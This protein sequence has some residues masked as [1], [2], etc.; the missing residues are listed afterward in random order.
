MSDNFLHAFRLARLNPTKSAARWCSSH[1]VRA[2]ENLSPPTFAALRLLKSQFH[3]KNAHFP[4]L[5][6]VS[7]TKPTGFGE[8]YFI[9]LTAS[10]STSS[11]EF[12]VS[13]SL[14]P[15]GQPFYLHTSH[16][17]VEYSRSA[18]ATAD[19]Q[20]E[21]VFQ[22]STSDKERLIKTLL[23]DAESMVGY[24]KRLNAHKYEGR[25]PGWDTWS[26]LP[27][28]EISQP[29][30][31][32]VYDHRI[33]ETFPHGLDNH[34]EVIH[35]LAC[36]KKYASNMM[37]RA[38]Y[39]VLT[40]DPCRLSRDYSWKGVTKT[41]DWIE[42]ARK[43]CKPSSDRLLLGIIDDGIQHPS[44]D[45]PIICPAQD[46]DTPADLLQNITMPFDSQPI[47]EIGELS[48]LDEDEDDSDDSLSDFMEHW[49]EHFFPRTPGFATIEQRPPTLAA[50]VKVLVFD[51]IGTILVC[52]PIEQLLMRIHHLYRIERQ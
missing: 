52:F 31:N 47:I 14:G 15:S 29:L 51:L 3:R 50:G 24:F 40:S 4:I 35:E 17:Y 2:A 27:Q 1:G 28:V 9:T 49:G 5:F 26:A 33:L 34:S 30:I 45:V 36:F 38:S 21:T 22:I 11:R 18:D 48:E 13:P 42:S 7:S 25:E 10:P 23:E 44:Q 37:L 12:Q 32:Q 39:H 43:V 20:W 6:L 8:G 41:V 46:M 16:H 19:G